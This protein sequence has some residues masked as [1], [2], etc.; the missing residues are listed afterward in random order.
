LFIKRELNAKRAQKHEAPKK[1]GVSWRN[2][3]AENCFCCFFCS[4]AAGKTRI[5]A[6]KE[7]G[8]GGEN[9]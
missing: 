4:G 2:C 1:I 3:N 8:R 6:E 9:W 5:R 7:G